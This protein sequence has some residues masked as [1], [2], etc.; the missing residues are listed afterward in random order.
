MNEGYV[1]SRRTADDVGEMVHTQPLTPQRRAAVASPGSVLAL[2]KYK[3]ATGGATIGGQIA[4]V[5][6]RIVPS[7]V[8]G[9]PPE[10]GEV[11]LTLLSRD[12]KSCKPV[13][14]QTYLAV[15]S[16]NVTASGKTLPRAIATAPLTPFVGRITSGSGSG[17]F[18]FT[19][20]RYDN[21]LGWVDE[22]AITGTAQ[23]PPI[24][25]VTYEVRGA[26]HGI[27]W[28]SSSAHGIWEGFPLQF[29]GGTNTGSGDL[30]WPGM[31]STGEQNWNGL[32]R[33]AAGIEIRLGQTIKMPSGFIHCNTLNAFTLSTTAF[34]AGNVQ[35]NC[36]AIAS[37]GGVS[38]TGYT[39]SGA[40][41]ITGTRNM[42]GADGNLKV[43]TIT[44]G[45]ITGW[46]T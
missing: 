13:I 30:Y 31:V 21:A 16:G 15:M 20:Q 4:Y 2:V 23:V 8:D 29:A 37:S 19:M 40:G 18:A 10:A 32:K 5:A 24:N 26:T 14:G 28:P 6:V 12:G 38:A 41:G 33:F 9:I 7:A 3:G 45:I 43:V 35:L 1:L 27:V 42:M 39:A 44:G 34:G 46:T 17:S 25:G 22:P 36:G 11:W